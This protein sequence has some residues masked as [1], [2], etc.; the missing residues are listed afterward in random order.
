MIKVKPHSFV[1]VLHGINTVKYRYEISTI[2]G[3]H[4]APSVFRL[5]RVLNTCGIIRVQRIYSAMIDSVIY[6]TVLKRLLCA[7]GIN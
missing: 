3:L 5:T 2:L 1:S 4:D 6:I 7:F